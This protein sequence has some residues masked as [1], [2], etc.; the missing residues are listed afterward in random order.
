MLVD[1]LNIE[2]DKQANPTPEIEVGSAVFR[3]QEGY[4]LAYRRP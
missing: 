1:R 2:G 4:I 3:W